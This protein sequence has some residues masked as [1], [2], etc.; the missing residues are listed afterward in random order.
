[1]SPRSLHIRLA[2]DAGAINVIFHFVC[3]IRTA[4]RAVKHA[5]FTTFTRG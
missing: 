2:P 4:S 3:M 1:M 5:D